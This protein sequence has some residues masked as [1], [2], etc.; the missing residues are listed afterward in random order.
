MYFSVVLGGFMYFY[1]CDGLSLTHVSSSLQMCSLLTVWYSCYC[2]ISQIHFWSKEIEE[3]YLEYCLYILCCEM[4]FQF[5][6]MF[7]IIDSDA[8]RNTL[9]KFTG[10]TIAYHWSTNLFYLVTQWL[11]CPRTDTI[12]NRV[13]GRSQKPKQALKWSK[14]VGEIYILQTA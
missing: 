5:T 9:C 4:L 13:P 6:D 1:R 7:E 10:R 3:L 12:S 8:N 14:W 2:F 11:C